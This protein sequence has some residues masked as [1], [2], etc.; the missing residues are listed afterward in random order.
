MEE[1]AAIREFQLIENLQSPGILRAVQCTPHELGPAVV[2]EHDPAAVRLDHFLLERDRE[3]SLS[4]R[5]DLVR[6]LA[7]VMQYAHKRRV[8]HRGNGEI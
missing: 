3:L 4:T 5:I 7:E 2:F 8:V 6:Q 1:R